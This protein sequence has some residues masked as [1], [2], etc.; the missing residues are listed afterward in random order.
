LQSLL[1]K[2]Y[3][4]IGLGAAVYLG[5]SIYLD[6]GLLVRA[7]GR[8]DWVA[9]AVAL[10]LAALN[11]LT[12][13]VRWQLY[14][15]SLDISIPHRESFRIFL[16]GLALSVTPGKAGELLKA[17][18]LR[19]SSGAPIGK[20]ASAVFAERLTDFISLLLLSLVG[21]YSF[22]NGAW[23]LAVVASGIVS[24]FLVLFV[25]GAIPFVLHLLARLPRAN[26]LVEPIEDAYVSARLLLSPGMLVR[27]LSIGLVAWFAECAGFYFVLS[28][29]G[30]A[31][32]LSS[33]TF[34]YAFSTIFGALTLLP[35]GIGT[36]EG[37]MTGLL[38]LQ[39]IPIVDA[40]AATFV[41]RVCT[42]WFAVAVGSLVLVRSAVARDVA[43]FDAEDREVSV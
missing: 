20:G 2:L 16:S 36:T 34:I 35:G 12:R 24:L 10:L 31:V 38:T 43:E 26:R 32:S 7:L 14:I 4:S 22:D 19:K 27:G 42:L 41:I 39:G 18:L 6:A 17:Y 23:T 5:F 40:A 29:F 25:P 11:Y 37:S 3:L 30:A 8:F 33:A 9:G 28:G 13:F 21:I 15:R 1:K